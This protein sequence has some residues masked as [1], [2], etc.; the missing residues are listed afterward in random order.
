MAA[1]PRSLLAFWMG[2]AGTL[3]TPTP[4]IPPVQPGAGGQVRRRRVRKPQFMPLDVLPAVIVA[5][6]LR[7]REG[8]DGFIA[9]GDAYESEAQARV[10]RNAATLKLL[11][12]CCDSF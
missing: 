9:S 2:G 1:A 4:P 10:R 6:T 5:G 3:G 8:A 12:M 7:V 11:K